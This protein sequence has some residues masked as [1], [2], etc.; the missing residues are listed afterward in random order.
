MLTRER[1]AWSWL[2]GLIVV[3]VAYF[4]AVA[5]HESA[6]TSTELTKIGMLAAALSALAVIALV[7]RFASGNKEERSQVQMDERDRQIEAR[8]S[9]AAYYVLMGGMIVVGFVMPF[10]AS[11]WKLVH[12]AFFAVVLAEVVHY[13]M[14]LIGYRRGFSG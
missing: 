5:N 11:G 3:S 1:F 4:I 7:A 9:A 2:S 14:V 13:A 12:A 10:S 6:S 8:S